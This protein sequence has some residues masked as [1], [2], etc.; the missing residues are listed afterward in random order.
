M[1]MNPMDMLHMVMMCLH[2]MG[3]MRPMNMPT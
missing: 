3:M 1:G 2:H